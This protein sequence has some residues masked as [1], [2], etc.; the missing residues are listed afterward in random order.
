M[1]FL[2]LARAIPI[3]I[4]F[5][6]LGA[7]LA[8]GQEEE[9]VTAEL[10]YYAIDNVVLFI[11]AILVLFMQAGFG[12]VEAGLNASKNTV[13]IL[14]KNLMDLSIGAV[15]YFATWLWSDVSGRL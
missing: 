5:S 14:F 15:L 12:M 13:N 9:P 11:A 7:S 2:S 3:A 4:V 6:L 10:A 8:L 1:K